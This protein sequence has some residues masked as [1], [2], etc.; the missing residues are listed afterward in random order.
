MSATATKATRKTTSRKKVSVS[1]PRYTP[2][3]R[4]VKRTPELEQSILERVAA[5][6]SLR[7]VCDTK[8]MPHAWT[9]RYWAV[10]DPDFGERF[11]IARMVQAHEVVDLMTEELDRPAVMTED[12]KVDHGEVQLRRL[13]VDT[14][15]WILAKML[16]KVYGDRIALAGDPEA[17]LHVMSDAQVTHEIMGLLAVAKTRQLRGE[18]PRTGAGAGTRSLEG[19][20]S[21]ACRK[22]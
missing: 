16:P 6:E 10:T 5:G 17:P 9:V 22:G 20:E 3:A 1:K 14:Y 12:G 13:R 11:K 19:E 15:K 4:S 18:E 2:P 21:G 8:G 7:S